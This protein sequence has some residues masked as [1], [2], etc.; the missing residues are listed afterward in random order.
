MRTWQPGWLRPAQLEGVVF[1]DTPPD[2]LPRNEAEQVFRPTWCA[3]RGIASLACGPG[4]LAQDQ[5]VKPA[6]L[7]YQRLTWCRKVMGDETSAEDCAG[8]FSDLAGQ[9]RAAWR[10][11]R[12]DALDR[13]PGRD[14]SGTDLRRADLSEARMEGEGGYRRQAVEAGHGA[15][16]LSLRGRAC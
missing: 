14:L 8:F 10:K 4:P 9:Y 12:R 1:V 5:D 2:W 6:C 16:R 15:C 7:A 13:L 3:A 11:A